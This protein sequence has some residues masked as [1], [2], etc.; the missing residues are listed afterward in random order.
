MKKISLLQKY[1]RVYALVDD[2]NFEE[3]NKY[4]WYYKSKPIG[5]NPGGYAYRN[6]LKSLGE[7]GMIWMHQSILRAEHGM[8]VDHIDGDKL[9]NQRGN[10]RAVTKSQNNQNRASYRGSASIYK[11]VSRSISRR[12]PWQAKIMLNR[13]QFYLGVFRTEMD[14]AKAYDKKALSFSGT[15]FRLNFPVNKC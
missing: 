10:L 12:N 4:R 7:R 5:H 3:L 15:M 9:N 13:K 14:A 2:D 1:A 8:E 11:G 6:G